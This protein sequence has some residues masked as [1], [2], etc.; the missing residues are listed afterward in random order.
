VLVT[1]TRNA[2][3]A[4]G[5]PDAFGTVAVGRRADLVLLAGDPREDLAHAATPVGVMAAGRWWPRAELDARLETIAERHV[6]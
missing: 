4:L 3:A 1:G 5:T 2:A 6:D